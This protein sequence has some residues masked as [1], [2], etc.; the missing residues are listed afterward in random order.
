M[1]LPSRADAEKQSLLI[2]SK[3]GL[4]AAASAEQLRA[5]PAETLTKLGDDAPGPFVDSH[6]IPMQPREA[7]VNQKAAPIPFVIGW[8]SGEYSLIDGQDMKPASILSM[9]SA[10]ELAGVRTIYGTGSDDSALARD[11]FRDANFAAP[12]RWVA[13]VASGQAKVYLYRFSYL[14]QSQAGRMTGAPHGSEV[15]YVFDSWRQSPMAGRF[16]ADRDRAEATLLH[17]CWVSFAKAGHPVCP[18]APA[19]PKYRKQDDELIDFGNATVVAP[20]L[21]ARQLDLLEAHI[22]K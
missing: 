21:E 15:P 20:G 7:F 4:P 19:W 9:F 14:R 16:L 10:D 22:A 18:D 3:A 17:A 13:R 1:R 11:V 6:V 8:N 2:A 12:S 5:L